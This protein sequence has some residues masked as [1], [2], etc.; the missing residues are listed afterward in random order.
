MANSIAIMSDAMHLFSDLMAFAISAYSV[1]LSKQEAPSYLTFGYH[2]V[3]TIGALL[4][5][6]IIWVVTI[7]LLIEATERVINKEVVK[8]PKW[9]LYTSIF[10]LVCNLVMVKIIHS[11]AHFKHE[12]CS[13]DH[14][15]QAI[16]SIVGET[17]KNTVKPINAY[18]S[19][20]DEV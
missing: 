10:G 8:E 19:I 4:N 7:I 17:W 14:K 9:M 5:I 3:Q 11:D 1:W 16:D 6:A 2:K 13:H 15:P 20:H 12:G 18:D